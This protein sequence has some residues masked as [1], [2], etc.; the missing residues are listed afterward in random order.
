MASKAFTFC[1][2]TLKK[3]LVIEATLLLCSIFW[4]IYFEIKVK[5]QY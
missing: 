3:N 5:D 1:F 4:T 2:K